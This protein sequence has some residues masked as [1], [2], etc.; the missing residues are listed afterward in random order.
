MVQCDRCQ[1][2]Y[3]SFLIFTVS[4]RFHIDCVGLT[5]REATKMEFYHCPTCQDVQLDDEGKPII[6]I[7]SNVVGVVIDDKDIRERIKTAQQNF[8]GVEIL[9]VSLLSHV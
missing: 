4:F 3:A 8:F 2:W 5:K 7:H 1:E 9:P 6:S